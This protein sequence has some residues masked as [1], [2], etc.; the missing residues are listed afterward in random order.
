MAAS[1]AVWGIDV[2]QCALK[3]LKLVINDDGDVEVLAEDYIEHAKILS[4]ADADPRELISK[5]LEK[6]LSRNDITEDLVAVGV[7]GQHTL[8]RFSK[9]P[10]VDPKKVPD[11]VQFEANQQIPFDMDEVIWDYQTFIEEDSP[12]IEVGIFAMKRDLIHEHLA[13]FSDVGIEPMLMQ[14]GPLAVHDAVL[15]DGQCSDETTVVVDI[16]AENTDLV[17]TDKVRIWTRTIPI[18]GNSFTEA[19]A[20]GFKLPFAKAENLKR[21]A[22]SSKYARQIF[23]AMRPIFVDLVGEIQ[24]SIGFYT[25]THRSAKLDRMVGMGDA[26][27]LPGLQKYLQQNLGMK[28]IRPSKFKNLKSAPDYSRDHEDHVLSF[29]VAY[30]LALDGLGK[31]HMRC[32]LLPPEIA[33]QV[34]WRKKQPWF[35]AAAACLAL[36]AGM[37]WF[38]QSAD[39]R[40]LAGNRGGAEQLSSMTF[41]AAVGV[42]NNPPS[43]GTPPREYAKTIK[44]MTDSISKKYE[45]YKRL[46]KTEMDQCEIIIELQRDKAL[47]PMILSVIHDS[48]PSLPQLTSAGSGAA[49]VQAIMSDPDGLAR[50]Q[51]QEVR[52]NSFDTQFVDDVFAFD[53]RSAEAADEDPEELFEYFEADWAQG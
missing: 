2:G 7:P 25:S 18:G 43:S 26:F 31:G 33:R 24:R 22:S 6:F 10:P 15:F 53:Y 17:V 20:N 12:E 51:R 35:A 42:F 41:S 36:C 5:S 40:A 19:L 8:A 47:W 52:I 3:A 23:Q 50:S 28:V 45:E 4:Q 29:G 30:G 11:I 44:L 49:Y 9:L 46:G 32:N 39:L 21:Q 14:S 37:V 27:R 1:N 16:G 13:H 34:T 38:R 48:V